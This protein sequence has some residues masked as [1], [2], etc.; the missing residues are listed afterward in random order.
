MDGHPRGA[1][2]PGAPP[3]GLLTRA[4]AP[5]PRPGP[6]PPRAGEGRPLASPPPD[7]ATGGG[8]A[9]PGRARGRAHGATKTGFITCAVEPSDAWTVRRT[10]FVGSPAAVNVRLSVT[11]VPKGHCRPA[12]PSGPSSTPGV[13]RAAA[14]A[15]R[16][17]G[18][19]RDLLADLRR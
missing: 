7:H 9:S 2:T 8:E 4:P 11:P 16:G 12:G 1:A 15:G 6:I 13:A 3:Q 18:A 19:E 10:Y 17:R 5:G 14:R